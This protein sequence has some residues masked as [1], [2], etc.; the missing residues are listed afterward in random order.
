MFAYWLVAG[1]AV[2]LALVSLKG[3]GARRRYVLERLPAPVPARM[4]AA[5]VIVPV[6]G[7]DEGLAA[8]LASLAALDYPDF[9][10]IV[11]ARAA[12]DV[13][14]H[15]APEGAR[16]VLAGAGHNRTGEKINNLMAAVAA[17][18]KDSEIFAFADSDGQVRRD[19]LRGLVAALEEPSAGAATGYRWHAPARGGFWSLLRSVW[20]A[21]IAGRFGPGEAEFAW[22]GAMA[23]RREEFHAFD[24]PAYW[25]GAIS[26]DYRLAEAVR[27]AGRRIVYAPAA[28]VA[29]VDHTNAGGLFGWT[30]R[31]M[32]V[33]RFYAPRLWWLGVA[34]H[35]VYCGGMAAAALLALSGSMG[36]ALALGVQLGAGMWKGRNRLVIARAELPAQA[37]WFRRYGWT[38]VWGTPLATWM[39]MVSLLASAW[40]DRLV[41]RGREY[42]LG[43]AGRPDDA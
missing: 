38:H 21:V 28:T 15:A 10:L 30:R 33:T 18:R 22:G 14:V 7:D 5:T 12:E 16:V 9:E 43:R 4:P 13:P 37:A 32:M 39:W 42:R 19:W 34:A 8:N 1:L 36:G 35:G 11:A 2:V 40:G 25:K 23:I 6:K 17:A 29:A 41:W 3:E 27:K 20:N 24:V 26:D 31:Q